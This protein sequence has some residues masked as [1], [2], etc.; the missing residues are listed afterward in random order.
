M[1][2]FAAIKDRLSTLEGRS[3]CPTCTSVPRDDPHHMVEKGVRL[4]DDLDQTFLGLDIAAG[5]CA[6]RG[7]RG[8]ARTRERL[9]NP[10]DRPIGSASLI[11]A[12]SSGTP[13]KWE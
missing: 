4:D 2:S 1:R 12:T 8:V 7:A 10:A 9:E 11:A 6:Y 5:Q 13:M 3:P